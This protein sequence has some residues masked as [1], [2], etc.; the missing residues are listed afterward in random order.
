MAEHCPGPNPHCARIQI[1]KPIPGL[2]ERWL[3][4]VINIEKRVVI[5]RITDQE[6]LAILANPDCHRPVSDLSSAAILWDALDHLDEASET[7]RPQV[8]PK[9]VRR[10]RPGYLRP[11]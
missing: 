1:T 6:A 9:G 3:G 8:A 5:N 11:E 4:A 7:P 2:S 10:H